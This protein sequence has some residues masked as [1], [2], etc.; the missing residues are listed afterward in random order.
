[1]VLKSLNAENVCSGQFK[2]DL[3]CYLRHV[4]VF[5]LLPESQMLKYS[6]SSSFFGEQDTGFPHW[7]SD[8]F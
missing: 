1:M 2:L 5:Y 8:S 4:F 7:H 6:H 3:V